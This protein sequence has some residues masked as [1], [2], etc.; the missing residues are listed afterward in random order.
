MGKYLYD[1]DNKGGCLKIAFIILLLTISLSIL[2]HL[3]WPLVLAFAV[4][5]VL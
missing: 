5:I 3:A 4:N 1:D 2:V